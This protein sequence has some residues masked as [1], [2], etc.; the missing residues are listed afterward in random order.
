M[1]VQLK[2]T[3]GANIDGGVTITGGI[4]TDSLK[5]NGASITGPGVSTVTGTL[6][7]NADPANPIINLPSGVI[8]PKAGANLTNA[9]ATINPASDAASLYT[10]PAATLTG[11]HILT[12]GVSGSPITNSI[13]QL[14]R[15]DLTSNTYTIKDDAG[16]TLLV[17]ASGPSGAQGASFYFN[18]TH[19]VFL[20]FYYVA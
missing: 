8:Q 2:I 11:A 14:I 13:V 4:A 7:N 1:S 20:S 6:V 12:L 16:T 17:F 5:I 3:S 15:R 18:G 9:D 19:Y 10:L